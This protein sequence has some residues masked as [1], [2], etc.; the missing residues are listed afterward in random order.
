MNRL[1]NYGRRLPLANPPET[2]DD[3]CNLTS[4]ID[5]TLV[6]SAFFLMLAATTTSTLKLP[7]ELAS[8]KS[9]SPT[10]R[11]DDSHLILIDATGILRWEGDIVEPDQLRLRL[12]T[13]QASSPDDVIGVACDRHT[14][15]EFTALV[16]A[17]IAESQLSACLI[18]EE[19][20]E[21]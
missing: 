6:L 8:T 13:L 20:T 17:A 2:E 19:N 14:P 10:G 4:A 3:S 7:L 5:L 15:F 11:S 9:G 21:P 1:T 18:T 16:L 12:R